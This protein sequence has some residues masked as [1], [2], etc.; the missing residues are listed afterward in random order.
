MPTLPK[1]FQAAQVKEKEGKLEIIELP[2]P[3]LG[4]GEVL[5]KVEACGLCHGDCHVVNADL[6]PITY[7]R[8][9]G[10]EVAGTVVA[11]DSH[12]KRWKVGDRVAAGW[13]GGHCFECNN[14]LHGNFNLCATHKFTGVTKDGGCAE[15]MKANWESLARIP[16]SLSFEDA[17]PFT[18]AGLTVFNSLRNTKA[19]P[20]SLVAVIGVGGLGKLYNSLQFPML[21]RNRVLSINLANFAVLTHYFYIYPLLTCTFLLM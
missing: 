5:V 14:C 9:P 8:I 12:A 21:D 16:D 3:T 20:G 19:S 2:L 6:F 1:T 17:A 11:I 13:H 10:H 18:C 7:P 15:Y 4:E